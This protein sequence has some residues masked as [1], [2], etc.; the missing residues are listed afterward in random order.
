MV[1]DFDGLEEYAAFLRRGV[2]QGKGFVALGTALKRRA[3]VEV[4]PLNLLRRWVDVEKSKG[5]CGAGAPARSVEVG[6]V[7]TLD[8]L[9]PYAAFLRLRVAD[10]KGFVALAREL[11]E[12]SNVQVDPLNLLRRFVQAEQK[13]LA[14]RFA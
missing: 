8:G 14:S 7:K 1:E 4:K 3:N 9:A 11:R 6:V 10:G 2:A 12:R 5:T 13:V